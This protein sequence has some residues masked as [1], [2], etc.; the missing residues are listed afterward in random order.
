MMDRNKII[1]IFKEITQ[2]NQTA[3]V[4]QAELMKHLTVQQIQQSETSGLLESNY[5][6]YEGVNTKPY[7]RLKV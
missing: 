7:Y 3:W 6:K 4:N 1:A 2:N 5:T